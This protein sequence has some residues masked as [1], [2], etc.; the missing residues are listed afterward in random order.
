MDDY[1]ASAIITGALQDISGVK[2]QDLR[3][4][5]EKNADFFNGLRSVYAIV[6]SRA[7]A[8]PGAAAG[9]APRDIY[10]GLT[11]NKRFYGTLNRE[12]VQSMLTL[13]RTQ[14]D[15][16]FLIIGR[17][18]A[19]YLDLEGEI[20]HISRLEFED[21][22]PTPD[23]MHDV[24]ELSERHA[25]VFVVYPHLVN[26]FRQEVVMTDITQTPDPTVTPG[27]PA[28]DY[29]FEPDIPGMLAFFEKQVRHAL[30][31]RVVLETELA[32]TAK[33]T[34]KMRDAKERATGL[35]STYERRLRHEFA[36]LADI[37]HMD[38]FIRRS[39]WKAEPI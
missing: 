22:M 2:L 25:R 6:K 30:L 1:R 8:V 31:E 19:E 17:T 5:F 20:E 14:H 12:I 7:A 34:M 11:S 16:D 32:R 28:V 26:I 39:F 21:D 36:T 23:E 13:V 3:G 29:I 38:T 4:Q 10:I 27:M 24:V 37:A 18:G 15:S 33:R 9:K 35:Q